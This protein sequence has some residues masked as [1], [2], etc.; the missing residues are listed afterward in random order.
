MNKTIKNRY[1][2]YKNDLKFNNQI[3]LEDSEFE[4]DTVKLIY[5]NFK[6]KPKIELRLED[7]KIENYKYLDLSN[8]DIDDEY[9]LK[10]FNLNKI[11]QILQKIE[12][13]DLSNNKLKSFPNLNKY[14]NIKYLNLSFNKIQQDIIDDNLLELTCNNN[15]IKSIKSNKIT[16]LNASNNEIGY[17]HTPN[18]KI[19]IIGHNK[20][21]FIQSYLNLVYLD[22]T[23]NQIIKIDNMINLEE[24][25]ITNNN[26]KN[27]SNMPKLKF[28]NC[29]SNPLNKIKYFPE[30]KILMSSTSKISA[31]YD[32]LNISKIKSDFIINFNIK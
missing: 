28:L 29:I 22:C 21:N 24:L 18:I 12:F 14:L 11:Q 5:D 32:V 23:E 4:S 13:F 3:N 17:L 6:N 31:Q 15:K 1:L 20:L 26:L 16:H 27:I 10:L 25:Y 2:I 9:L 8:L 19:L 7:S 30:L